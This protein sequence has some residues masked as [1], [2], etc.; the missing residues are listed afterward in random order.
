MFPLSSYPWKTAGSVRLSRNTGT[1]GTLPL[2]LDDGH[3]AYALRRWGACRT[4][5][6]IRFQYLR[7]GPLTGKSPV[8]VIRPQGVVNTG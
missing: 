1:V 7:C 6:Y 2:N 3:Q 8:Q 4:A 5:R